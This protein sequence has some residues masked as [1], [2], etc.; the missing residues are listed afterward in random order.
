[1][2]I[3]VQL[4]ISELRR[5]AEEMFQ[6]AN[7]LESVLSRKTIYSAQLE[8]IREAVLIECAIP[9]DKFTGRCRSAPIVEARQIYFWLSR[10]MTGHSYCEI[11]LLAGERDH[12]TV[13]HGQK[14]IENRISVESKLRTKVEGL[15]KLFTPKRQ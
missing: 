15:Q 5:S 12:G 7:R 13:I 1:M 14:V 11:G 3:N 10:E 6:L 8:L 9:L 4:T 2:N